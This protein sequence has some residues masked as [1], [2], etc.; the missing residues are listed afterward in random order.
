MAKI[1]EYTA[2][3]LFRSLLVGVCVCVWGCASDPPPPTPSERI[4]WTRHEIKQIDH[5]RFLWDLAEYDEVEIESHLELSGLVDAAE[6]RLTSEQFYQD[7]QHEPEFFV[8]LVLKLKQPSG[9]ERISD[10]IYDAFDSADLDLHSIPGG[11]QLIEYGKKPKRPTLDL[12]IDGL[13]VGLDY[14]WATPKNDDWKVE[15]SPCFPSTEES[16]DAQ[17]P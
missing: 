13:E 7:H 16:T 2:I 8:Q 17:N 1:F 10:L 4:D 12:V 9:S 11:F 3:L 6:V 15:P 14:A 5:R